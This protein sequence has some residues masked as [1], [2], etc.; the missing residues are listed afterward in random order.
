[1]HNILGYASTS[2]FRQLDVTTLIIP[3]ITFIYS[4]SLWEPLIMKQ[5]LA[6]QHGPRQLQ[7]PLGRV[8]LATAYKNVDLLTH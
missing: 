6:N 5:A 8:L 3:F 1:M 4:I 2:F 7:C